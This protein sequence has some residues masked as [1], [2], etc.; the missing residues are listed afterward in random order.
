MRTGTLRA[1]QGLYARA[2]RRKGERGVMA[3]VAGL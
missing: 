2:F 3:W 1:P